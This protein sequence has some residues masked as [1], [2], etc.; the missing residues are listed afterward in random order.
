MTSFFRY[1][2]ILP[3]IL[4]VSALLRIRLAL[5]GGQF[6]FADEERYERG[7]AIYQTLRTGDWTGL[8]EQLKWPEH[9][10]FNYVNTLAAALQHALAHF[11]GQ[12]DWSQPQNIYASAPLA[13][14]VLSLFSVLNIWLVHRLARAGG[15]D[16]IEALGAALLAA[17]SNTLFY[18]SRHLLP[19]DCALS[20]ALGAIYFAMAGSS[21]RRLMLSGAL[22]ALTFALYNGYWFLVPVALLA[23]LLSQG[24]LHSMWRA[25][26]W[27]AVGFLA[28]LAGLLAPGLVA[29]GAFY[30]RQT[31][32]FSHTVLQGLFAEG[33][34]L[35]GEYL[36]HSEGWP[37]L[38]VAL[39]TVFALRRAWSAD[40]DARRLRRWLVLLAATWLLPVLASTGL[41][42]FVV[43]ARTVRPLV[44]FFCLTGGYACQALLLA[45]PN[46]RPWVLTLVIVAALGNFV[47]H[48]TR[49]FPRDIEFALLPR[50]GVTKHA[51]S[52]SGT[53]Y[54]PLALP[55]TRPDLALVN[56]QRLYPVR[57]Y[58]GYPAGVVL[59][60]FPHPLAYLPY[61]YEGHTPRE[62]TLL[63]AHEPAIKLIQLAQ[64]ATVPDHPS[65]ALLFQNSDRADGYDHRTER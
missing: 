17:A 31:I 45:R 51:V 30:C 49:V 39:G 52:F 20:A 14:A 22:A 3:A 48:F 16:E 34:S 26:G 10:A 24:G 38:I 33:W 21:W 19:Y 36:W 63:R 37:G 29:G 43:Y 9:A 12:G 50:F 18:Y 64:P 8:R 53:I 2:N 42:Q 57:D 7:V 44:P 5:Q 13:A 60:S 58:L 27:W 15:A 61:Q 65:P 1:R 46:L 35:A 47:P 25:G 4:V 56:A 62:R 41:H 11:T 28:S 40:A 6:F 59:L 23:L 32:G 55:V 54:R